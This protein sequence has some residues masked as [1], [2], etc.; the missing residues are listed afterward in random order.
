MVLQGCFLHFLTGR[1]SILRGFSHKYFASLFGLDPK[2][3]TDYE[4]GK[5]DYDSVH[6]DY[7]SS[8]S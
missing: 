4:T 5:L 7:V 2:I 6:T 8:R 3:G 1:E